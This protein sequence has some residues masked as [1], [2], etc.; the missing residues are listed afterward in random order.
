MVEWDR[1]T[2]D[3]PKL[4][5]RNPKLATRNPNPIQVLNEKE[6]ALQAGR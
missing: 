2:M 6:A 5:T 4:A 3:N 1:E